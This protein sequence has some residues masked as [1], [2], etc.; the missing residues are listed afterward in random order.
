MTREEL[1]AAEDGS[2][3][4]V[5]ARLVRDGLASDYVT[6]ITGYGTDPSAKLVVRA[7]DITSVAPP[8]PKPIAEGDKVT[9]NVPGALAN[10]TFG[11]VKAIAHDGKSAAVQWPALSRRD[12]GD[13]TISAM[14]Y[15]RHAKPSDRERPSTT[16]MA[17]NGKHQ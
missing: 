12:L 17:D 8:P 1:E 10:R 9:L 11:L 15:L 5:T 6:I 16:P 4:T 13:L 7:A 14:A 2:V 3:V